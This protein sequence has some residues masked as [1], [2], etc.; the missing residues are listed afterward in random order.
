MLGADGRIWF[1]SFFNSFGQ[2][3][4]LVGSLDSVSLTGQSGPSVA[5]NNWFGAVVTTGPA[6]NLYLTIQYGGNPPSPS[7]TDS[8]VYVISTSA[9]ILHKFPLPNGSHPIGIADGSDHNLWIAE[10]GSNKIARMT[11]AGVVTQFSLPTAN[12]GP[13]EITAAADGALRSHH[14]V[15]DSDCELGCTGNRALHDELSPARRR[16]VRRVERQQARK[17]RLAALTGRRLLCHDVAITF[18][19]LH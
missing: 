6:A 13:N 19:S 3:G 14:R 1:P 12:A 18:H 2:G 17:I 5:F 10:S 16:L 15:R 8:Y 7:L 4:P 9:V 11:P